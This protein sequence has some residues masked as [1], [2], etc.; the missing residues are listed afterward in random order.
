MTRP[1][2]RGGWRRPDMNLSDSGT[3]KEETL[4]GQSLHDKMSRIRRR[5]LNMQPQKQMES[6]LEELNKWKTNQEFLEQLA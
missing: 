6:M 3:R 4:L 5:L 2:S 1:K